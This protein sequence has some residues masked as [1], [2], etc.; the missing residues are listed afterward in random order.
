MRKKALALAAVIAVAGLMRF[1]N[2]ASPNELVF[3]EVYYVNGAQ[4]YLKNGVETKD[5]KPE[6]VVHPP[7]GKWMI[8]A[9]I[10]LFGDN[11]FGWRFSAAL[12][13]TLSI[14][15]IFLVARKLFTSYLLGMFA[16]ILTL[17]DGLHLVMS[18]T[19]LLDIF[20]MFFLLLG[21]L[22]TLYDRH[23]LAAMSFGLALG[24]KWNA[25]YFIVAIV[26]YL[27]Y[28]K[29]S[30]IFQ[31]LIATLLAYLASWTGWFLSSQ[32]WKR[33]SSNNP[34]LALYNY[35]REIL[36]F[37]T[38]LTTE[39][40]YQANPWNWLVLGRPTSFFYSTSKDCGAESCAREILALG[41]PLL[42]WAG[43]FAIAITIGY[44][45]HRRDNIS[46]LILLAIGASYLPWFLFQKRT[47]F[48]FYSIAF[49]PF[50]ILSLVYVIWRAL[51]NGEIS[52]LLRVHRLKYVYGGLALIGLCFLYFLPIFL[53]ISLPYDSW[54]S[55]M[56]LP[57]WI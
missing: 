54:Y 28:K 38:K 52:P 26:A 33:D 51:G 30:L 32:G 7:V 35:H 37:H 42:W 4:D 49:E 53:G 36:N 3:D 22:L 23:W 16:A 8:A 21:F 14:L 46:F 45:L 19:A 44:F 5:G 50:L 27:V 17:F 34:F 43:I 15:L 40:S 18:R 10:T 13:G 48:Y 9:G 55:R 11:S 12:V 29:R 47:M 39:H 2:L 41:T 31:Y 57:S 20:L 56:W 24:T 25:L 1:I 6:F